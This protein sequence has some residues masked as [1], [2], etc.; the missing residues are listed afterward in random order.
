MAGLDIEAM[1]DAPLDS[2]KGVA[3]VLAKQVCPPR[4][5]GRAGGG[6]SRVVKF[7]LR[8]GPLAPSAPRRELEII[9]I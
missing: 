9:Y 3:P 4:S 5:V 8:V 2:A 1:L 7:T 6:R